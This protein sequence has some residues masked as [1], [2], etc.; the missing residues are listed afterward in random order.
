VRAEVEVFA[1]SACLNGVGAI[2]A[3]ERLDGQCQVT[4]KLADIIS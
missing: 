1:F 4:D 2:Y 3:V